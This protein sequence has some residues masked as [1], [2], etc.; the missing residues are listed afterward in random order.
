M[1]KLLFTSKL[2]FSSVA[3]PSFFLPPGLALTPFPLLS[4][5]YSN[6]LSVNGTIAPLKEFTEE[7]THI[8]RERSYSSFSCNLR[9]PHG[10]KETEIKAKMANG[11]LRLELPARPEET[12]G[13]K[14]EIA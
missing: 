4:P 14:I 7:C 11:V 8:Q 6:I 5:T 3:E 9:V 10:L 13:K 2:S 12:P 1:L